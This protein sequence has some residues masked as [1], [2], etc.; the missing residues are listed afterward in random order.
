MITANYN[1]SKIDKTLW[2]AFKNEKDF[3]V[4]EENSKN[5]YERENSLSKGKSPQP[6]PDTKT[7]NTL[8]KKDNVFFSKEVEVIEDNIKSSK[9]KF[10]LK[11]DQI[12][13][14]EEMKSLD[15]G[16][17]DDVL[18]IIIRLQ[19]KRNRLEFLSDCLHHLRIKIDSGF[20]FKKE[21]IAFLRNCL[22]GKQDII[23]KQCDKNR[24][25]AKKFCNNLKWNSVTIGDKYIT[26]F[27]GNCEKEIPLKIP[28]E[29]FKRML[30]KHYE[31]M[32][33]VNK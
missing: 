25:L 32:H 33:G 24:E 13:I 3:G 30:N 1:K 21:K 31:L 26:Y 8:S 19:A 7:T 9:S 18:K 2:Y 15:L 17:D 11:K 29:D 23:T 10:V 5:V 20:K 12:P 28:T 27:D 14:F 6:I 16:C 22:S 4:S